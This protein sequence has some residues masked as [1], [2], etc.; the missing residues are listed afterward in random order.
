VLDGIPDHH[1]LVLNDEERVQNNTMLVCCSGA[2][3]ERLV[4]DL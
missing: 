3:S 4:L 2:K 1:D